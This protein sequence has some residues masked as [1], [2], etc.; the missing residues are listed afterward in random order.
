M[1][2]VGWVAHS[3]IRLASQSDDRV[4]FIMDSLFVSVIV[5]VAAAFS[6][7]W[8]LIFIEGTLLLPFLCCLLLIA[9]ALQLVLNG[10]AQSFLKAQT[11]MY[12]ECIR[13][14]LGF[15]IGLGLVKFFGL[16][17]AIE[18]LFFGL[19]ISNILSSIV[20]FKGVGL[21]FSGFKGFN[22]E[23]VLIV[24]RQLFNYGIYLMLWFFCSYAL[25]Y[26]DR[27]F[28]FYMLGNDVTGNYTALFDIISRTITISALP[29][30]MTTFPILTRH[31]DN[32]E[33][34]KVNKIIFNIL[35]IEAI[36]LP[37]AL[38]AYWLF[39]Y[40]ILESLLQLP[41]GNSDLYWS[42]FLIIAGSF[43]TQ[44]GMA[45]H[46]KFELRKK[47][48]SMFRIIFA[49]LVFSLILNLFSIKIFGII[50]AAFTYF[51]CS[52]FYV[53]LVLYFTNRKHDKAIEV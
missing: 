2:V 37:F 7:F 14:G 28:I 36:C 41:S 20:L 30:L 6:G 38:V 42:G 26:N 10:A 29:V 32:S 11:L 23:R 25:M 33:F 21:N 13:V 52:T 46:K 22:K 51:L 49:I 1:I 31:Y 40:N 35:L 53:I 17:L 47:T 19:L 4:Q 44:M 39:G 3:I 50:G 15:V 43:T 24:G 16:T 8:V 12:A 48:S 34:K 45:A 5:S 27:Y 9:T 18:K